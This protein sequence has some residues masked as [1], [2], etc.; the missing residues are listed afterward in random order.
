VNTVP[1]NGGRRFIASISGSP[2]IAHR[3]VGRFESH[4]VQKRQ[5]DVGHCKES[6]TDLKA[7]IGI[8]TF[9]ANQDLKF[10]FSNPTENK[11]R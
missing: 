10:F 9:C 1:G 11:N 7:L 6:V 8:K 5:I 2:H 4:A 3:Q